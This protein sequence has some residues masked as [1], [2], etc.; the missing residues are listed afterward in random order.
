MRTTLE[1][2]FPSSRFRTTPDREHLA[3]TYDSTCNR[4]HSGYLKDWVRN[5]EPSGPEAETLPLG[6][7]GL[8]PIQ[9][10]VDNTS[11]SVSTTFSYAFTIWCT[12]SLTS[13]YNEENRVCI[14]ETISLDRFGLK[15]DTNLKF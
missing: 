10:T 2:A 6:H 4:P 8:I 3:T 7:S 13:Q 5:L 9:S 14:L 15:F 1:L 11:G 12:S